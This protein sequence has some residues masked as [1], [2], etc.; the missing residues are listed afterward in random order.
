MNGKQLRTAWGHLY[1]LLARHSNNHSTSFGASWKQAPKRVSEFIRW[2]TLIHA[3]EIKNDGY[4]TIKP[5]R[6]K[7]LFRECEE[8]VSLDYSCV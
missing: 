5:H 1:K 8:E 7:A 3:S 6:G 2:L 4:R